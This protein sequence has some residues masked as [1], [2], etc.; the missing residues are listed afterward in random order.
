MLQWS[1]IK[2][3]YVFGMEGVRDADRLIARII[4]YIFQFIILVVA[5]WMPFQR[6]L[7][8]GQVMS[9]HVNDILVWIFWAIALLET[10]LLLI[11]SNQRLFYLA[12]NWLYLLIILVV[13]PILWHVGIYD[14][15]VH[16]LRIIVLIYFVLPW[17]HT[18]SNLFGYNK[19]VV[20]L[21]LIV[22]IAIFVGLLMSFAD[23]K[24]GTP[25]N[26]IWW[27]LQTITTVGYGDVVPN[28]VIGKIIG[29][30]FMIFA[31]GLISVLS[32]S[33]TVFFIF[34][35]GPGPARQRD[36]DTVLREL[37]EANTKLSDLKSKLNPELDFGAEHH[38]KHQ[39]TS[40]DGNA[41]DD[42]DDDL[43]VN[44]MN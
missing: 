14:G 42:S 25:W 24:I 18:I 15:I 8:V 7:V 20:T 16:L 35:G 32:A 6:Y 37:K 30:V 36:L 31:V 19:L 44:K 17:S 9:H 41:A 23:P 27:S 4:F 11:V 33:F 12:T 2:W 40:R 26:G 10:V 28:N 34:R 1:D 5:F 29:M 13:F 21:F 38:T 22:I 3:R 43:P 39:P